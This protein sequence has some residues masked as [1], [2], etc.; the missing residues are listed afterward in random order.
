MGNGQPG[1]IKGHFDRRDTARKRVLVSGV[2]SYNDGFCTHSCV[3][4]NLSANGAQLTL[5]GT[6]EL[7]NVFALHVDGEDAPRSAR[8]C[9]TSPTAV[10]VEFVT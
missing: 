9:W 3:V 1:V 10:G 8:V 2:I 5:V 7:P 6:P 4:R